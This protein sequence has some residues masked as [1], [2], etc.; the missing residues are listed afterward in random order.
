LHANNRS[1]SHKHHEIDFR[2]TRVKIDFLGYLFNRTE[3]S[4]MLSR[5]SSTGKVFL[6]LSLGMLMFSGVLASPNMRA[7]AAT[8]D[9]VHQTNF[10]Q[11]CSSGIGVG[12]TYDGS[13]LWYS[14][15]ASG[16]T[17]DLIKADPVTGV[18]LAHY[19]IEGGIGSMAYDAGRNV[20]WAAEAGG[21]G[22]GGPGG[23]CVIAAIPLTAVTHLLD[24][25]K[26]ITTIPA[27][28]CEGIVDGMAYDGATDQLYW[29]P[30]VSST[31]WILKATTGAIV[32]TFAPDASTGCGNSGVALGGSIIY[33]G[34]NG[35][36]T[37]VGVD[38]TTHA[39]LFSFATKDAAGASFRD[40]SMTC[41]PNTFAASG[42]QVMWTKDAYSPML[43]V[44]YEITSGSCGSGGNPVP[45]PNGVPEFPLGGFVV[46][47]A[48][49]PL[50]ALLRARTVKGL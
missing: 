36:S 27:P 19:H 31:I 43:A 29:S 28:S 46:L 50:L 49:I 23:S 25:T 44:A 24:T 41:D 16:G 15:Y 26:A 11:D 39:K 3:P 22:F 12:I 34:F 20:I 35:C 2:F 17:D 7:H 32:T 6:M 18:V 45:P 37:V 1:L 5:L 33:E 9:F 42:K 10:T 38:K 30:D 8:G 21:S 40:E 48:V 13:S 47:A 4:G 14:C